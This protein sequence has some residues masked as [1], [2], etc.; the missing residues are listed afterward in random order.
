[1]QRKANENLPAGAEPIKIKEDEVQ[2]LYEKATTPDNPIL[3]HPDQNLD[4][5]N[6]AQKNKVYSKKVEMLLFRN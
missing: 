5:K 1:L 6:Q 2:R 4:G 3:K